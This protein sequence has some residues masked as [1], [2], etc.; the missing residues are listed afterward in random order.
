MPDISGFELI[1]YIIP[2]NGST[3]KYLMS[4]YVEPKHMNLIESLKSQGVVAGFLQKPFN[5]AEI[6]S[7]LNGT[8]KVR[9]EHHPF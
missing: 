1:N 7:I 5:P 3:K 4:G 8:Y 9:Q 6:L 2:Y